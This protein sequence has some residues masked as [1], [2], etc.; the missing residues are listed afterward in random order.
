[1]DD[2]LKQL[3]LMAG[4]PDFTVR[5]K[6]LVEGCEPTQSR[7]S[8]AAWDLPVAEDITLHPQTTTKVPTGLAMAVPPNHFG[9]IRAR[10]STNLKTVS[11]HG[12]V[13]SEYRG[14]VFVL[15]TNN[16][17]EPVHVKRG[18]R[19]GQIIVMPRPIVAWERVDE[20]DETGRGGA[21]FGSS[22][23]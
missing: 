15:A 4:L 10:S 20:L 18:D 2:F 17:N 19:L 6:Q 23:R 21:G 16:G 11:V 3:R 9:D 5:F 13:D 14:H 22:G 7:G 8:D 12:V 1:V